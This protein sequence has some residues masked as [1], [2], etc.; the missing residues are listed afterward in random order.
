[1]AASLAGG[2]A[3]AIDLEKILMPGPVI[4]GHA[5]VEAECGRCHAPFAKQAQDPLCLACHIE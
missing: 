3:A 1:M 4:R 5:D 2:E